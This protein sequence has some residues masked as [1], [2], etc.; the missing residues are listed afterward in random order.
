[1][2]GEGARSDV[3]GV[4]L[5]ER[6]QADTERAAVIKTCRKMYKTDPR[7]KKMHRMM[8]RDLVRGG[9][10]VKT[11]NAEARQVALDLQARMGLNQIC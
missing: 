6:M 2:T 5:M 3:S 1:M 8:A 4:A 7:V 10:V 9:F 11:E